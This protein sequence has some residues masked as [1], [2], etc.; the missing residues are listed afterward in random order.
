MKLTYEQTKE[1]LMEQIHGTGEFT[2]I[3]GLVMLAEMY[4]THPSFKRA[5]AYVR[6]AANRVARDLGEP[7]PY[8]GV[9]FH[10][11]DVR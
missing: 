10:S 7:E 6:G 2:P 1:A 4:E 8:R 11:K 9:G 5:A 3:I